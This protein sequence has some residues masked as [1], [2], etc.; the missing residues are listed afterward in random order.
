[1]ILKVKIL[2]LRQK[3]LRNFTHIR[4]ICSLCLSSIQACNEKSKISWQKEGD[5]NSK[6]F[7]G[8]MSSRRISNS[9]VSLSVNGLQIGGVTDIRSAIFNHFDNHFHDTNLDRPIVENLTYKTL[10]LDQG[11]LL[12]KPFCIEE[13]KQ[14]LWDCDS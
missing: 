8:I 9:I 7:Y 13:L 14:A 3:R 11:G 6:F 1:M 10:N 4:K 5:A 12:T 2:F